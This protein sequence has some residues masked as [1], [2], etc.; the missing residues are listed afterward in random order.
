MAL[1]SLIQRVV[2]VGENWLRAKAVRALPLTVA[3]TLAVVAVAGG[4]VEMVALAVPVL[5]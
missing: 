2:K 1:A 5:S 3:R 4:M